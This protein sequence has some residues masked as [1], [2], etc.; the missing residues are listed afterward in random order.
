METFIEIGIKNGLD[1]K[2]L[3]R[4][5]QYMLT[6][7]EKEEE[8]QCQTGYADEWARRFKDGDEYCMSDSEG[9]RVLKKI[10]G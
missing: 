4:Y 7:W 5:T 10:D 2:T 1:G 3:E 6:R 9:L 8:M